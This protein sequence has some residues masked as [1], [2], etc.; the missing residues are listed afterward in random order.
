M[1]VRGPIALR[2]RRSAREREVRSLSLLRSA[3]GWL[4]SRL[5]QDEVVSDPPQLTEARGQDE[6][7]GYAEHGSQARLGWLLGA[8]GLAGLPV[9]VVLEPSSARSAADQDW[10]PLSSSP[11]RC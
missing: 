10:P 2:A 7:L 6:Q 8:L 4:A 3:G 5:G 9:A 1:R 11:G